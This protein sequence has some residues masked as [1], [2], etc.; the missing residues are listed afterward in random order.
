[1]AP[2]RRCMVDHHKEAGSYRGWQVF[3][4]LAK[5]GTI[6][7]DI[8]AKG[9]AQSRLGLV[10]RPHMRY[11]TLLI[12]E[13]LF[14]GCAGNFIRDSHSVEAI[15]TALR[16]PIPAHIQQRARQFDDQVVS[17][18][19]IA[20]AEVHIVTDT[21]YA[22]VN[23][24]TTQLL[25]AIR[26]DS[27]KWVVRVLDTSPP[28]ENAFVVGGTYIYVYTGL[29]DRT[30]SDDE[31]AF[32]L[33]HEIS[34]SW[35]KHSV[36]RDEDFFNLVGSLAQMGAAFSKNPSQKDK[37]ALVG[38]SLQASYSREDEQ[39]A[40]ALSALIARQARFDPLR[41]IEFFNR[42]R[43]YEQAGEFAKQQQ[44]RVERLNAEQNIQ[45]CNQ[46]QN[47]WNSSPAYR[48]QQNATSL[49][50]VCQDAQARATRY[51]A[52]AKTYFYEAQ[53]DP[54]LRTHPPDPQ[55]IA[56][57]AAAVDYLNGRRPLSSLVNIGQGYKVFVA[58]EKLKGVS[59]SD[60]W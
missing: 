16:S 45:H 50:A 41:G 13:L 57:L 32:V 38:G 8:V 46:L 14:G 3:K 10:A 59:G 36:R 56:A 19:R 43:G 54:L 28:N 23:R 48:T 60:S 34:H 27:S 15:G 11:V 7:R 40:D 29:L 55:R 17:T 22:R 26:A 49:N 4:D 2:Q 30:S 44:L 37:L 9:K 52:L 33:A 6:I 24:I 58:L 31:L 47:I 12:A 20:D 39:E 35:L 18:G 21:R 42:V 1:M 5:I 53:R 51:N 25:K